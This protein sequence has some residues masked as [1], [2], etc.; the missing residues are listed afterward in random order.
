MIAAGIAASKGRSAGSYFA[1]SFF[2]TPVIGIIA[3][4]LAAPDPSHVAFERLQ[5]G[6]GKK[7]P[8]CAEII[9]AEAKVCRYCGREL[10]VDNIPVPAKSP[11]PT[12]WD[13][14]IDVHDGSKPE[15]TKTQTDS[16]LFYIFY[17]GQQTGPFAS[18]EV[19][20][21]K[22]ANEIPENALCWREGFSD[23]QPVSQVFE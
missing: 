10:A 19:I 5:T 15:P 14:L 1:V 9:K 4:L 17:G 22:H 13:A 16:W 11:A 12:V 21:M 8:Y 7:C 23:W 20:K 6:E 18:Q 3:A 2:F